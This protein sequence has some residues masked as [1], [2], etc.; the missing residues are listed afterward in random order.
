[1]GLASGAIFELKSTYVRV[2]QVERNPDAWMGVPV[3]TVLA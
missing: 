1:M 2:M 3:E